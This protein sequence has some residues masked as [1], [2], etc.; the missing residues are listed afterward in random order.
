MLGGLP[1]LAQTAWDNA[2]I[3]VKN[4]V[5]GFNGT[6]QLTSASPWI[7]PELTKPPNIPLAKPIDI[8]SLKTAAAERA[9][10][11]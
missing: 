8:A 3:G 6:S 9:A 11:A 4:V 2:T 5:N 1:Q 10:N 7:Q